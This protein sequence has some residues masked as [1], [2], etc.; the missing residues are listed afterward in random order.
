M[1]KGRATTSDGAGALVLGLSYQNLT[2]LSAGQPI[3]L[4]AA[5]VGLPPLKIVIVAGGTEEE[6]AEQL[7]GRP[8]SGS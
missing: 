1:L 6:L 3:A 5:D 7:G 2:R 4:D 8:W